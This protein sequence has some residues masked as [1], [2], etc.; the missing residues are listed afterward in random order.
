MLT[1][2]P[3]FEHVVVSATGR[4]ALMRT[5]APQTFVE[6][7]RWLADK[8]PNRPDAKRRRDR[9]QAAIVQELLDA[10]LLLPSSG[11]I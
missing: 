11:R 7:K 8:A 1:S 5:I 10:G 9:S 2:A 4:M 6:F 3:R